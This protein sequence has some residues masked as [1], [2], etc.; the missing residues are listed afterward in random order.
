MFSLKNL[1][2]LFFSALIREVGQV[3]HEN[4][5]RTTLLH[6]EN[7]SRTTLL[8]IE[9]ISKTTFFFT[10]EVGQVAH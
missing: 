9:N 3:A 2:Q 8:H 6:I 4:I 7:I 10:R 1:T 5:S